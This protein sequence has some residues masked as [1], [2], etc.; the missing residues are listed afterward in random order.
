MSYIWILQG[1]LPSYSRR[2]D[3]QL[4]FAEV[5]Y[6]DSFDRTSFVSRD[7]L[8]GHRL[9]RMHRE[10]AMYLIVSYHRGPDR[11]MIVPYTGQSSLHPVV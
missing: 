3:V 6:S 2:T 8:A 9:E 10:R 7:Q 5:R 1:Q 11:G 4:I